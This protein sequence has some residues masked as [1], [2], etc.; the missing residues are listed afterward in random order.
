[1]LSIMSLLNP[2][3]WT[4]Q[5]GFVVYLKI[6]LWIIAHMVNLGKKTITISNVLC[7]NHK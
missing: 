1:M 4:P 2:K 3:L 6:I 5:F 7:E